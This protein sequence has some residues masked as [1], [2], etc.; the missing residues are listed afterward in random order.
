MLIALVGAFRV[1]TAPSGPGAWAACAL[2]A[3]GVALLHAY[4]LV[5]VYAVRRHVLDRR[6]GA[7]PGD[8]VAAV[9][10]DRA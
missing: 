3:L 2:G 7:G 8:P 4:D 10:G 6:A 1:H 9:V 5:V